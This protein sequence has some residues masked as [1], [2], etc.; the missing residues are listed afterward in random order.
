M[1]TSLCIALVL[2]AVTLGSGLLTA[3]EVK[4]VSERYVSASEELLSMTEHAEWARAAETVQAYLDTWRETM[5][6]LQMLINH[7]DTDS[8]TVAL[9]TLRAAIRA[10]DQAGCYIA[11]AELWENARHLYHRDAFTLANVL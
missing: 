6:M 9:V 3:Q 1:R 7:E 2:L 11:C 4:R 5:P 8:V 10:E